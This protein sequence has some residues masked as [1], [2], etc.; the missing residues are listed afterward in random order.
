M[1]IK[2]QCSIKS[3]LWKAVKPAVS[4]IKFKPV[5]K[6]LESMFERLILVV[7]CQWAHFN[8]QNNT[9]IY[10]GISECVLIKYIFM[11]PIPLGLNYK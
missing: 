6:L 3:D 9:I 5:E 11:K 1:R 7:D 4:D 10:S 2:K 8:I